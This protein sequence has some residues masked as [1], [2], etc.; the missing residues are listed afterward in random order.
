M[1]I[2]T[3][4][5]M[6]EEKMVMMVICLQEYHLLGKSSMQSGFDSYHKV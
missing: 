3:M 6:E 5:I 2:A 1:A 4:K